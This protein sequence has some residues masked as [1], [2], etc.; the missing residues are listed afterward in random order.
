VTAKPRVRVNHPDVSRQWVPGS[1]SCDSERA[2]G[3]PCPCSSHKE[4]CRGLMIIV[5]C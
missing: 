3:E 5:G 1:G 4:S 2:V